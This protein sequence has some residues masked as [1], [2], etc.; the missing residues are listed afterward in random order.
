MLHYDV[1]P[2]DERLSGS[3]IAF[4]RYD[5]F[6]VPEDDVDVSTNAVET[7]RVLGSAVE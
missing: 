6:D 5:V 2:F 7:V 4:G 1:L 3:E